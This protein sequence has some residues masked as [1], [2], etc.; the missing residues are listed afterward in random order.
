MRPAQLLFLLLPCAL[1]TLPGCAVF[2]DAPHYRGIAVSQHDLNELTPGVSTQADAQSLLGPP[3]F[4]EP[5]D[6]NNW[7]YVSQVTKLRIGNTEGVKRQHVVILH[8]DN[9]GVLKAVT[10]KD[11]KDAMN[12]AMDGK[13]TPV[14]GG[15]ASFVQQLIGGVGSYNPLGTAQDNSGG[16]SGLGGS[17]IGP[18]SSGSGF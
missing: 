18:G 5:F 14:P 1:L 6:Q 3:T 17:T 12:V 10:Q 4:A 2:S 11:T 8:F 15:H 13:T 7:V 9:K 16:V